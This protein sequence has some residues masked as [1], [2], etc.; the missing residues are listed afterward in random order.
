ME[1]G[2]V[3]LPQTPNLILDTVNSD[4]VVDGAPVFQDV[5]SVFSGGIRVQKKKILYIIGLEKQIFRAFEPYLDENHR[6][7]GL[8]SGGGDKP[9]SLRILTY[10]F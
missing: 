1:W 4:E 9:I 2:V 6:D 7:A 5:K 8:C 3:H 10:L